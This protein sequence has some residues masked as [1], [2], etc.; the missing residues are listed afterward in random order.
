ML[1]IKFGLNEI[2][3][4]LVTLV[5]LAACQKSEPRKKNAG[6]YSIALGEF[7]TYEKADSFSSKLNFTKEIQPK[8][9][10]ADQNRFLLTYGN[11]VTSFDAGKKAFELYNDSLIN[12]YKI[13]KNNEG[14]VDLFANVF[15]VGKYLER[16]SI[17]NYNLITKQSKLFW[18]RWGRK[19]LSLAPSRDRNTI[20]ITTALGYGQQGSF[21]YV[22]EARLYMYSGE[23]GQVNEVYEFGNGLQLY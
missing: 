1:K 17:Y 7:K 23:E 18:S 9:V 2:F 12:H 5:L 21:P 20:F 16:P 4:I 3:L 19:V 13:I 14:V 8:I 15:F 6:E 11:F 22:R 10:Q